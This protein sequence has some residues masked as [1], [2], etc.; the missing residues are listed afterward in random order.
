MRRTHQVNAPSTQSTA[1]GSPTGYRWERFG[2]HAFRVTAATV[3][4]FPLDRNAGIHAWIATVWPDPRRPGG[5]AQLPWQPEPSVGRGW[6]ISDRLVC[7]D[8]VEFGTH[9]HEHNQTSRWYGIV[10]SYDGTWLVLQGPYPD[11]AHAHANAERLL[12]AQRYRE[13]LRPSTG[14]HCTRR[15]HHP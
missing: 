7:G 8:V 13:P 15:R 6:S 1:A 3:V 5:W 12:T 9:H 14:N 10:D 2:R 11:A 4:D